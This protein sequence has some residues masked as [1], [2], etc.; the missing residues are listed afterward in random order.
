MP[1]VLD[2]EQSA[3]LHLLYYHFRILLHR[4]FS[5]IGSSSSSDENS[6]NL[7]VAASREC[8]QVLAA[9]RRRGSFLIPPTIFLAVICAVVLLTSSCLPSRERTRA[10]TDFQNERV[11]GSRPPTPGMDANVVDDVQECL[12]ILKLANKPYVDS[13]RSL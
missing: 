2:F 3:K 1:N 6:R 5:Q 11:S 8:I 12:H 4:P 7:C 10:Q 9:I 13:L